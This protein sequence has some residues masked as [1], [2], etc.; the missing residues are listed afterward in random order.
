MT[1]TILNIS[2]ARHSAGNVKAYFDVQLDS[3][4]K[5][6]RLRL[7]QGRNGYRVYG[8]RDQFGDTVTLP[9]ALADQLAIIAKEAVASHGR[10]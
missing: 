2:P 10:S 5:L 1:A 8:P 7:T 9:I 3:G 4:L 6:Y